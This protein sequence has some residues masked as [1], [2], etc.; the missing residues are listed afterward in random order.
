MT[1]GAQ[2]SWVSVAQ[3]LAAGGWLMVP[4][5]V[6]SFAIWYYYLGAYCWYRQNL[7][8]GSFDGLP[9]RSG[10]A[11]APACERLR[12]VPGAVARMVRLVLLRTQSGQELREACQQVREGE[13]ASSNRSLLVLAAWVSAAPLLGLL[14]TVLGMMETFQAV[15]SRSGEAAS[16]VAGG[17]SQ[18]LVTTQ[19]GLVAALP[20]TLGLAHLQR[21]RRRLLHLLDECELHLSMTS[22]GW[23]HGSSDP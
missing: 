9:I 15:G 5:A 13:V 18:A 2:F 12:V 11:P 4:L 8:N 17:I 14:G 19:V 3:Y 16:L 22:F 10:E 23:Q 7:R 20:G 6:A 21:L 1:D